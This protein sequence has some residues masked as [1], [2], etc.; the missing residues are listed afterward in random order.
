LETFVKL[1]PVFLVLS[2]AMEENPSHKCDMAK[3]ITVHP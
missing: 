3:G 2:T 1:P